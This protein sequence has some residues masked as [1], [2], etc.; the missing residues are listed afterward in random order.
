M[1]FIISCDIPISNY[2]DHLPDL[3]LPKEIA[4]SI[5][6]LIFVTINF[7]QGNCYCKLRNK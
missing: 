2:T 1:S 7:T 4:K 3:D 6:D 5:T